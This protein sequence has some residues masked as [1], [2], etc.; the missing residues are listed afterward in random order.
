MG[1]G[2]FPSPILENPLPYRYV[3]SG[4]RN[5]ILPYTKPVFVWK[6]WVNVTVAT[7]HTEPGYYQSIEHNRKGSGSIVE[8]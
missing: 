7:I 5:A 8:Y 4:C 2:G 3:N 1:G 6:V